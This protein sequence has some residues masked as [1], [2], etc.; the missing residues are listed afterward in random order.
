MKVAENWAVGGGFLG[1]S[2]GVRRMWLRVWI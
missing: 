1:F 2:E